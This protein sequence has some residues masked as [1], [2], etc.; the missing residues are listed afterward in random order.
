MEV[1]PCYH[2][3]RSNPVDEK[4]I[5]GIAKAREWGSAEQQTDFTFWHT[6]ILCM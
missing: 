1:Q 6:P 5:I 2:F 3:F 4:Q